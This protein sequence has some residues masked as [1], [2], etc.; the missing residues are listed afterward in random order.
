VLFFLPCC[1]S[2]T[3]RLFHSPPVAN[4]DELCSP[5][6]P[7][8]FFSFPSKVFHL[9]TSRCDPFVEKGALPLNILTFFLLTNLTPPPGQ[10]SPPSTN[11]NFCSPPFQPPVTQNEFPPFF[12]VPPQKSRVVCSRECFL[13]S[14]PRA[15]LSLL[16]PV[17]D[18][19]SF[20]GVLVSYGGPMQS[21]RKSRFDFLAL[22]SAPPDSFSFLHRR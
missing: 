21:S 3:A 2:S 11:R 15:T 14:D 9:S 4:I 20:L 18:L 22:D 1:N 6:S 19:S 17:P 8:F 16:S 12:L 5:V 7:L 13:A 10:C